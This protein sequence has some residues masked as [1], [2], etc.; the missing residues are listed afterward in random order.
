LKVTRYKRILKIAAWMTVAMILIMSLSFV[1][2]SER[3]VIA[4]DLDILIDSSDESD[5]ISEEELRQLLSAGNDP[6]MTK[7]YRQINLPEVESRL[8]GHPAVANAEV[9]ADINGCL[10]VKVTQRTPV[11]RV[12][13]KDGE[14]YY[15]DAAGK[16]MPLS[17]RYTARVLV[18]T[19]EL[20]EPYA[21]RYMYTVDQIAASKVFSE[22]SM[23]DDLLA[24]ADRIN[25][26][27]VLSALIHQVNVNKDREMELF[28]A[29]G[30]HKIMLGDAADVGEKLSKLKLFYSQ[31]LSRSGGWNKYAVINLK[32]KNL[33]V[34]TKK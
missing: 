10:H 4:S 21:R 32:Y 12:I 9:A 7:K 18:A 23:L 1:A 22:L 3:N 13:N 16:L 14:S 26:D 28:P 25:S 30:E 33:V 31:G 15:I 24:V 20:L 5:F 17:D 34:C 8:K 2:K 11:M 27:S 29:I 6:V 19:G